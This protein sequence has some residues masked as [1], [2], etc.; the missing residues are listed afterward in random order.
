MELRDS[1]WAMRSDRQP[2]FHLFNEFLFKPLCD[3]RGG[4][5]EI[6]YKVGILLANADDALSWLPISTTTS[7]QENSPS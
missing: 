5:S 7:F 4:L 3:C 1:I 2:L 6:L